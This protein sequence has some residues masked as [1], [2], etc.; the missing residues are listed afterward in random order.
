MREGPLNWSVLLA[1]VRETL[2]RLSEK[3]EANNCRALMLCLLLLL[4]V[5]GK[6][7]RSVYQQSLSTNISIIMMSPETIVCRPIASRA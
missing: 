6:K 7:R 3:K 4:A 5:F 2:R 1:S